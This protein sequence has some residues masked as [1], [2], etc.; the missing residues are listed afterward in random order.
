[1]NAGSEI[2]IGKANK[3][4]R[5]EGQQQIAAALIADMHRERHEAGLGQDEAK[6]YAQE[7]SA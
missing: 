4:G 3:A 5:Q 1:V 7:S 6:S 2:G